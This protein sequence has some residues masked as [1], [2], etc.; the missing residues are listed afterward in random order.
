MLHLQVDTINRCNDYDAAVDDTRPF[1]ARSLTLSV[2]LGLPEPRLTT[3]ALMRLAELFGI[4]AGTQRTALSRMAA[5]GELVAEAG[6]YALAPGPL[7]ARKAVQD[8]GR[9]PPPAQWDG[10]WWIVT[11]TAPA[12]DV[13]ERRE[14]R[15]AMV[16]ARMGELR[17]DTWLRPA[18]TAPPEAPRAVAVRGPLH[19]GDPSE[20]VGRLWDLDDLARRCVT[21]SQRVGD[22][23]RDLAAGGTSAVVSAVMVAAEAVRFLRREPY[24]PPTL[25]PPRW[26]VEALRR[27]HRD[28]DRAL[29]RAL[30]R[31]LA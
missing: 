25:A 14:F 7:L 11:V 2:L 10:S 31:A 22:A 17:A 5:A 19:G 27:Q 4:A 26:P 9:R 18:N 30:R 24:L 12:R 1:T 23:A 13:T 20:L 8:A 6:S 28:F 21:T 15:T 3:P 16:N 29:G